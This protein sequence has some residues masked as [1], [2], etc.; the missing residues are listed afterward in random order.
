MSYVVLIMC[1]IIT[2]LYAYL[3]IVK[4]YKDI[5]TVLMFCLYNFLTVLCAVK[6]FTS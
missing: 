1:F 3:V 6:V 4:E 5:W 2:I